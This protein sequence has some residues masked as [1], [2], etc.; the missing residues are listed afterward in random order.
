[1]TKLLDG[2]ATSDKIKAQIAQEVKS[3]VAAGGK[4]PHLAAILVGTD[5]ASQT[6]VGHKERACAQVGFKSTLLTFDESISEMQHDGYDITDKIAT[7]HS[8]PL[9][10]HMIL[11]LLLL[12]Q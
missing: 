9:C 11:N 4:Q 7:G 2:K 6:Y 8:S 3:I 1:M 5:G 12:M 10:Y